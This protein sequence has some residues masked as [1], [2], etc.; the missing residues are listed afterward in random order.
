MSNFPSRASDPFAPDRW[1]TREE[2]D[3]EERVEIAR[4]TYRAWL[5]ANQAAIG[6]LRAIEDSNLTEAEYKSTATLIADLHAAL[7]K[8]AK[9]P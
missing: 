2:Q 1:T 3:A 9:H 4:A 5:L 8:R 6:L 7:A